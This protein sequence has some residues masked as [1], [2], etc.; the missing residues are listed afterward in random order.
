[1]NNII[2]FILKEAQGDV[3]ANFR[4][5]QLAKGV[6]VSIY[7]SRGKAVLSSIKVNKELRGSGLATDAMKEII[8]IADKNNIALS[9]SPTNEWGSSK[10]RLIDFYKRFGFVENKGKNKD[11]TISETMFRVPKQGE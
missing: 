2:D 9:L 3:F 10:S 8:S 6:D 4:K 7:A 5:E 1:M 11:F